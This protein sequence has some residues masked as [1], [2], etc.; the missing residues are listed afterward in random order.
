MAI[1]TRST[2]RSYV[3]GAYRSLAGKTA[4]IHFRLSEIIEH[5]AHVAATT[6]DK[7]VLSAAAYLQECGIVHSSCKKASYS[8]QMVEHDFADHLDPSDTADAALL[9]CIANHGTTC[10]PATTPE[11]CL[12]EIIY[13]YAI[14]HYLDYIGPKYRVSES[15]FEA[16]Q[17]KRINTYSRLIKIHPRGA[18]IERI[19][20]DVFLLREELPEAEA[21]AKWHK[22]LEVLHRKFPLS[23]K[24]LMRASA[25][26]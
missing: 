13:A 1:P 18:E 3:V 6:E 9:D 24:G 16:L 17:L 22:E 8:K 20:Q 26:I 23:F 19:L 25:V 12:M 10:P 7:D 14:T 21:D 11:G 2:S 4:R 5:C 15:G